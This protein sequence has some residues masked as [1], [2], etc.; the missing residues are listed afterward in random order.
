[1]AYFQTTTPEVSRQTGMAAGLPDPGRILWAAFVYLAVF[2]SACQAQDAGGSL[3]TLW[4]EQSA[5]A[6]APLPPASTSAPMCT[7]KEFQESHLVTKGGWPGVGPFSAGAGAA[8]EMVDQS[9]NRLKV[10]VSDDKVTEA[11]LS[12]T[13]EKPGPSDFL[14]LQMSA[15]FLLEAVGARSL[16]IA[17]FNNE[18]EKNKQTVLA[19]A[20]A[21]PLTLSAGRYLLSIQ[22][23]GAEPGGRV[24]Y[25]LRVSSRD[26]SKDL[27]QQHSVS[28]EPE[29]GVGQPLPDASA[30]GQP[31]QGT[32]AVASALPVAPAADPLLE[33]FGSVIK[34]WQRIKKSA[35]RTRQI[36]ELSAV[37]SGRALILQTDAIK[38]LSFNRKYWDMTPKGVT[39]ERYSEVV[40]GKKYRVLA[41]VKQSRKFVDDVTGQVLKDVEDDDKVNY[42]VEKIG[43]HWFITDYAI[44]SSTANPQAVRPQPGKVSR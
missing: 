3:D 11:A 2:A 1:M 44:V 36:A 27:L 21:K 39:V 18:L 35:T 25:L 34:N 5:A 41:Q 20:D 33:E 31:A 23:E 28:R 4:Q 26:I 24:T 38:W 30:G 12:L 29:K 10:Q 9:S 6:S 17:E 8:N 43:D 14:D 22:K 32:P 7:L 15:N 16:K 42:T 40:P 37:L 13:R 19:G